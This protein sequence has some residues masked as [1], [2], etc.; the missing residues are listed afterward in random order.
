MIKT[1]LAIFRP[2][3]TIAKELTAIRQLYEL[4]LSE[5]V[6]DPQHVSRPLIRIT[7]KP[8]RGDVEVYYPGDSDLPRDKQ[9]D[10]AT[11]DEEDFP[12]DFEGI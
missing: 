9:V 3:T 7:E 11:P 4:E 6:V 10:W 1:L 2:L 12:E 5:R 8:K